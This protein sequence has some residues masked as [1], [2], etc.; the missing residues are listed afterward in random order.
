M[1]EDTQQGA[2]GQAG[3]TAGTSPFNEIAF[4]IEQI[5]AKI[6]TTKVVQ[7]KAVDT[8]AGTV[9][10][11]PMVS[12][13]DGLKNATP[14]GTVYG[15]PYMR[16]YGGKNAVI[17]K[18]VVGDIGF[19][20]V[21]DRDI[22]AVLENR[23]V[24]TPASFRSFSLSDGIYIGGILNEEPEQTI[25][26]TEGGIKI[27]DKNGNV[28]E[29]KAGSIDVTTTAFRVNGSVIAGYGTGDQVNLQTHGH[30][31]FN[32]PPTPGS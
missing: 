20:V 31:A 26:F 22:S 32:T 12:Q 23:A 19:V 6:S 8:T 9:D 15:L 13:I 27:A 17:I 10:V 18:P 7:I 2:A 14:H 5:L 24:S 28:I 25:E 4:M 11:Q 16:L 21:C 30:T 3:L 1:A 29:M